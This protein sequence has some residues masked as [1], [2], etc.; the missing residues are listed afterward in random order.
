VTLDGV[1]GA[2]ADPTRRTLLT[3]LL[4]RGA[5]TATDLAEPLPMSRQA[6]V[7]H[8]QVLAQADLA[9]CS[10]QGRE[11]HWSAHPAP[12]VDATEWLVRTGADWDRRLGRLRQAVA[13]GSAAP[14][15]AGSP[16]APG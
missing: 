8:L 5:A 7:K 9:R 11:V 14:S 10:R 15:A 3:T 4:E 1:F 2:L 13:N 12:L 6:V 16:S